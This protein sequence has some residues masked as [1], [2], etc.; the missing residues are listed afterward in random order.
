[1]GSSTHCTQL[2]KTQDRLLKILRKA[3]CR[4]NFL[5]VENIYK[6]SLVTEFYKDNEYRQVIDHNYLTRQKTQGRYKTA[7]FWNLYSMNTL[8]CTMPR[9]FNEL[10]IELLKIGN[11]FKRKQML[12]KHFL[13]R[14][15]E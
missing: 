4:K 10:P 15:C 13:E 5:S 6:I 11:T 7:K 8:Q 9:L 14:Q 2:Q 1:M 12:K 3:G